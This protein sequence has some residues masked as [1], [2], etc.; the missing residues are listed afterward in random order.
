VP[1]RALGLI[2]ENQKSSAPHS[3]VISRQG[4]LSRPAVVVDGH[5]SVGFEYT[6][7]EEI[8]ARS[9]FRTEMRRVGLTAGLSSETPMARTFA[10][11]NAAV[12][13]LQPDPARSTSSC[14]SLMSKK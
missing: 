1:P 6:D 5:C 7:T 9:A 14:P 11:S 2:I 4:R 12:S 3:G 13:F 8:S 10:F